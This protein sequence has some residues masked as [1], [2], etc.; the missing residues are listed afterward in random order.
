MVP[1][2][3]ACLCIETRA[4]APMSV[5]CGWLLL[6]VAAGQEHGK[7]CI[8]I[9]FFGHAAV[10]DFQTC[11]DAFHLCIHKTNLRHSLA[12]SWA[13]AHLNWGMVADWMC[14]SV[15]LHLKMITAC[16]M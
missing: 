7:Q 14:F 5:Y 6:R 1:C 2:A 8:F 15:G 16:L 4:G 9:P 11:R 13:T 3:E 12:A 10:D